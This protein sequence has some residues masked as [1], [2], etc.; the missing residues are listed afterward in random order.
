MDFTATLDLMETGEEKPAAAYDQVERDIAQ[1]KNNPYA[2]AITLVVMVLISVGAI[3]LVFLMKE[4][5]KTGP[6]SHNT[7]PSVT[8][9]PVP[10]FTRMNNQGIVWLSSLDNT[11]IDS[12]RAAQVG[13]WAVDNNSIN[14]SMQSEQGAGVLFSVNATSGAT[15]KQTSTQSTHACF[16][17]RFLFTN[18]GSQWFQWDLS[19]AAPQP[20]ELQYFSMVPWNQ[21]QDYAQV[22]WWIDD[23]QQTPVM[24]YLELP[25]NQ[26]VY[27]ISG[28]ILVATGVQP[29]QP[30]SATHITGN[31][32]NVIQ[33]QVWSTFES[34]SIPSYPLTTA[35]FLPS[36]N[37]I[38]V[39]GSVG[40]FQLFNTTLTADEGLVDFSMNYDGTWIVGL[41]SYTLNIFKRMGPQTFALVNMLTL[42]DKEL[43]AQV[44]MVSLADY[45]WVCVTFQQ[46]SKTLLLQLDLSG[47]LVLS[48]SRYFDWINST[49]QLKLTVFPALPQNLLLFAQDLNNDC[50]LLLIDTSQI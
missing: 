18:N 44:S 8:P 27:Q 16:A 48:Q 20:T 40:G 30:T 19:V 9:D 6:T 25:D 23:Q 38:L 11:G 5:D 32:N 15:T 35:F 24:F 22:A 28:G 1:S 33:K 13:A 41:S 43:C 2:L 50:H 14:I 3:V 26:D 7:S 46:T 17:G 29:L 31:P 36:L 10:N 47:Q 21:Q 37:S 4:K 34:S 49:V 12:L 42:S 39:A 45:L